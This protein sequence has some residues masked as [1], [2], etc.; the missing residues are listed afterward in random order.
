MRLELTKTDES[1]NLSNL[2]SIVAALEA[3]YEQDESMPSNTPVSWYRRHRSKE[4]EEKADVSVADRK[5]Q[6]R[7]R[8][9]KLQ[10]Q[11]L[12]SAG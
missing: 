4:I 11:K 9:Q 7:L 1:M 5:S 3:R 2:R 10:E 6:I 12:K 8:I